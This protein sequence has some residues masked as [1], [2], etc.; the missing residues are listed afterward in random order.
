[1]TTLLWMNSSNIF[2]RKHNYIVNSSFLRRLFF[3]SCPPIWSLG[4]HIDYYYSR[5]I[6]DSLLSL[7]LRLSV[8][9]R[10]SRLIP[11][12]LFE[13]ASSDQDFYLVYEL[14]ALFGMVTMVVMELRVSTSFYLDSSMV[15]S[16]MG[17]S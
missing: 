16:L 3:G 5:S 7:W 17:V 14:D 11:S 1:M 8:S 13:V 4:D 10:L 12:K 2:F 6:V 15:L 9:R